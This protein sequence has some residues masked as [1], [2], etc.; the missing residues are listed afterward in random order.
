MWLTKLL[1]DII[2]V[3]IVLTAVPKLMGTVIELA[4]K[5]GNS[6]NVMVRK[7]F[8]LDDPKTWGEGDPSKKYENFY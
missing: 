5:L 6:I 1:A 7:M 4:R 2:V 8:K 3:I